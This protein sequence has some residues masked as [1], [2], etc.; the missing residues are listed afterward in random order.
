MEFF[1]SDGARTGLFFGATSGVITT[2]G[3]IVGLNSGTRSITA[4]LGGILVIAVADAMSDALGIHLAEEAD[5]NT[6][7]GH[8]W[9]ATIMTFVTK[10][11]FSISFAVPL[12]LLPLATAV[13]V[14]VVWGLLVIVILSYFLAKSQDESPFYII[15]EHLGIAILVLV[16]SH[17]I[18]VWVAA[19]FG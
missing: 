15:G 16:L 11:V 4:V 13:S 7:H 2:I 6:D 18:G 10:F 12:L 3:L 9:A 1:K 19:T 8:V 17:Y 14:S 5:P